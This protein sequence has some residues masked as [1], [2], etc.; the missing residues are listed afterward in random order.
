MK[1]PK[2]IHQT[3]PKNEKEWHPIWKECQQSW[4]NNFQDFE[5]IMWDDEDIRDLVKSD[6]PK[7][8]DHYDSWP[9]HIMRVDFARFCILH[10]YGGIYADMDMYCYS[11]FYNFLKNKS[12]YLIE[13]WPEWGEKVSNCLMASSQKN[14]FWEICME[15]SIVNCDIIENSNI[16][17]DKVKFVLNSFGPKY[18]S[19]LIDDEIGILP[20][21]KFYQRAEFQFNNAGSEYNSEKYKKILNEF[22]T[23]TQTNTDFFTRHCLTSVW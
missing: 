7:F 14:N 8:L 18:M 9:Y 20:K 10:K 3:A 5:Y 13:S 2:I 1:I 21:E 23:L 11:N 15:K 12:V 17:F 16:S 6:Y 4:K 22:Y 19:K